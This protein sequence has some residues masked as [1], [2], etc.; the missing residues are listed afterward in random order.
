MRGQDQ[1]VEISISL[2]D[3]Y[4]GGRR[5]ITLERM[6]S[7]GDGSMHSK[8]Q[9]F[10]VNIPPGVTNGRRLRLSGQGG[11]GTGGAAAGDLYLRI[12]IAPHHT[13]RVKESNLEAIVAITPWEAALGSTIRVPTMDGEATV[14]I[15]AG[16]RS[17]QK[18]RLKG[19]GLSKASSGRGDLFAVVRITVPKKLSA[20]EKELFEELSRVSNF[21]PRKG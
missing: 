21:E 11:K 10:E 17:E 3:A 9:T 18:V 14:K 19:K 13:F 20:R 8:T 6:E 12:K 1:E 4:R 5:E 16:I 15:P 7:G 2:E